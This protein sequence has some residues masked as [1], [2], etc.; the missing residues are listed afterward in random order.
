MPPATVPNPP[1]QPTP[2]RVRKIVAFLKAGI[3]MSVVLIY[4]W[5]RG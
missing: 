3:S 2:L 1:M 5:R 4:Q